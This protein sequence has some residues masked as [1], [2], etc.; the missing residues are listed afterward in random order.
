MK[1]ATNNKTTRP[2][3]SHS[4]PSTP[5][6]RRGFL[7]AVAAAAGSTAAF[8]GTDKFGRDRDWSGHETVAYPEPA[9][10]VRDK[11]FN[12]R[13]GNATLQRIW[14]GTGHERNR[15]FMCG[16]TSIYALYVNAD[17]HALS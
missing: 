17:G 9:F 3:D 11:R 13:Q 12:G 14:H 2:A 8:A 7:A 4:D 10:E 15:L 5:I 16:S 6:G 1:Q